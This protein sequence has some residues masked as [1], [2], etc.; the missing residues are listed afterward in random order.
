MLNEPLYSKDGNMRIRV[1]TAPLKEPVSIGEFKAFGR[2]DGTAEDVYLTMLLKG[3]RDAVEQ[4]LG[5]AL[6]EQTI[7]A[8]MDFWPGQE[9][10]LP[11]PPLAS[12]TAIRTLDEDATATVYAA[13]G[14]FVVQN[15]WR[16]KVIIREGATPP[17]NTNRYQ[18]GY[19][20]EYLA[21]YGSTAS[22]VP[23]MICMGIM[24]WAIVGYE[25]RII[26][27][28]PPPEARKLLELYKVPRV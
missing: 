22:Y 15:D 17:Q 5:R 1:K 12:I 18:G 6:I 27:E 19:E 25:N 16:P 23:P 2:I 24:Q 28:T 10:I 13:T 26:S 8:S 3:V 14:Y 20:V 7:V 9:L 4:Y 11:R 21:G